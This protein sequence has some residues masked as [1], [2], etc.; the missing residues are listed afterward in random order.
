M[1]CFPI[2]GASATQDR[3]GVYVCVCTHVHVCIYENKYFLITPCM[4]GFIWEMQSQ[5]ATVF[6]VGKI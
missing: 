6:V 2:V 5:Y 1:P 4:A 3:T